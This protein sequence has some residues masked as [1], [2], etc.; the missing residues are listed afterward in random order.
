MNNLKRFITEEEGMGTVEMVLIIVVLIALVLLF[1]DAIVA[2]VNK[3]LGSISSGG[4]KV[5]AP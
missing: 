1:K 5:M 4:D 3:V 2:F